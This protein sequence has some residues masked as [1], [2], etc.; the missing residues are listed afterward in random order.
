MLRLILAITFLATTLV[1]S[2]PHDKLLHIS[3]SAI[4]SSSIS[5]FCGRD[6]GFFYTLSIGVLKEIY[7]M[8]SPGTPDIGDVAADVFGDS[9]GISFLSDKRYGVLIIWEF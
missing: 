3:I 5:S 4:L 9:L 8:F 1:F 7:D 6:A 2:F